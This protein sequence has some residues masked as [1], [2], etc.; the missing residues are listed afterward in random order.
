MKKVL[1]GMMCLFTSIGLQAGARANAS[2]DISDRYIDYHIEGDKFAVVYVNTDK[3]SKSRAK[4]Y[5]MQRA[6]EVTA[7]NGYRYFKIDS[8]GEVAVAES[9]APRQRYPTNLYQEL[10][11]EGD[12][13]RQDDYGVVD[14]PYRSGVYPAYKLVII[15]YDEKPRGRSYD[16]C[17]MTDCPDEQDDD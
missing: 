10:I 4:R 11:I 1:L 14:Y 6:A 16:A 3:S 12:F 8:E 2:P 9:R 17:K 7:D 5:A 15:C 13:G